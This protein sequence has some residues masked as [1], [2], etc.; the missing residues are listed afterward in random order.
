[1]ALV[2]LASA[3]SIHI[4]GIEPNAGPL[5]GNTRVMVRGGPFDELMT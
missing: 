1:M 3:I 4:D 5:S 2:N